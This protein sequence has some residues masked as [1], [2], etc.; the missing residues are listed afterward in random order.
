MDRYGGGVSGHQVLIQGKAGMSGHPFLP[1]VP[2]G[3]E[4]A[5]W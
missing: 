5:V 3:S 1:T 2:A 4:K